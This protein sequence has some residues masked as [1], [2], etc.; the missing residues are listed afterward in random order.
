VTGELETRWNKALTHVTQIEG[1]IASHDPAIPTATVDPTSLARL[2]SDL[3]AFWN[4]ATTD[5]R[6]KKR[7]VRT[8]IHEVVADIDPNAAEIVLVN[9][10]LQNQK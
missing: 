3:K 5:A 9:V 1:K 8:V 10:D 2:A 7:I 6:L 4:A